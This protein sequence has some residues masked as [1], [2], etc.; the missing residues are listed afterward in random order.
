MSQPRKRTRSEDSDSISSDDSSESDHIAIRRAISPANGMPS[1]LLDAFMDATTDEY[2]KTL[3]I[4]DRPVRGRAVG[5]RRLLEFTE[6]L[7]TPSGN[8]SIPVAL[9]RLV[10]LTQ[11][12]REDDDDEGD[13]WRSP[14]VTF[15]EMVVARVASVEDPGDKVVAD[16]PLPPP[17]PPG[18]DIALLPREMWVLIATALRVTDG[19]DARIGLVALAGTSREIKEYV[20][21]QNRTRAVPST[22]EKTVSMTFARRMFERALE[23]RNI[24]V[25]G[26]SLDVFRRTRAR[27]YGMTRAVEADSIGMWRMVHRRFPRNVNSTTRVLL[28]VAI[29]MQLDS[30]YRRERASILSSQCGKLEL[31][32]SA[33]V[34]GDETVSF[35][36]RRAESDSTWTPPTT[37]HVGALSERRLHPQ[38]FV[39]SYAEDV[40]NQKRRPPWS[41]HT[42]TIIPVEWTLMDDWAPAI[43]AQIVRPHVPAKSFARMCVYGDVLSLEQ[44]TTAFTFTHKTLLQRDILVLY[45]SGRD[46]RKAY[47]NAPFT[48][49]TSHLIAFADQLGKVRARERGDET[50]SLLGP[51]RKFASYV[52]SLVPSL[53]SLAGGDWDKAWDFLERV[54]VS[55]SPTRVTVR[56]VVTISELVHHHKV[57]D[58]YEWFGARF[59][60]AAAPS[61]RVC[62]EAA[63]KGLGRGLGGRPLA[64]DANLAPILR[65]VWLN[66][67]LVSDGA[68]RI[69]DTIAALG[70]NNVAKYERASTYWNALERAATEYL[71]WPSPG[72]RTLSPDVVR[73][74]LDAAPTEGAARN[75][76][77]DFFES[78][79]IGGTIN[80]VLLTWIE[81]V[82][83]VHHDIPGPVA[84][85]IKAI[86]ARFE[87][88]YIQC[89][90][91]GVRKWP[92]FHESLWAHTSRADLYQPYQ[93]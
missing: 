44:V 80:A 47:A 49:A 5:R 22:G 15:I 76:F 10:E 72:E 71:A 62:F 61:V 68:T 33:R 24:H 43:A 37:Q 88:H 20:E 12:L 90:R 87:E 7:F 92:K 23:L 26:A 63:A 66:N 34:A 17:L 35:S 57:A 93:I 19:V 1:E 48:L 40:L 53:Q 30:V 81:T 77:K 50:S 58:P 52:Y 91:A 65:H 69:E 55:L 83:D 11:D 64:W 54:V 6:Q 56:P 86:D 29:C 38:W 75:T 42:D 51:P 28:V 9:Q 8:V 39:D 13:G 16:T 89:E 79:L 14:Y 73:A 4:R 2:L 78:G 36:R 67:R 74:L 84:E 18:I 82:F 3:S 31:R 21:Y 46:F 60:A 32:S 41:G 25:L 70:G 27:E 45:S 59:T 85:F